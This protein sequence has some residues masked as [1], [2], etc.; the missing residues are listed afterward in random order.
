[1]TFEVSA[2]NS[3]GVQAEKTSLTGQATTAMGVPT[4]PEILTFLLAVT[5]VGAGVYVIR[6][7]SSTGLTPA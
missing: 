5:L 4:M 6:R 3:A 1:M 7:R 2:T